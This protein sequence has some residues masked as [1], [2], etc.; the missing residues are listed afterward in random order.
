MNQEQRDKL[1]DKD[2]TMFTLNIPISMWKTNDGRAYPIIVMPRKEICYNCQDEPFATDKEMKEYCNKAIAAYE[3]AV[4]LFKLF[5]DG[6]IDHIY[7][8][9]SPEGYLKDMEKKEK[10]N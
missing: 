5:R 4:E 10:E 8:F 6:K 7:C 2:N 1:L 3:N 9:D